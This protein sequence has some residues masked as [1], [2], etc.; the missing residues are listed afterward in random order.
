MYHGAITI[1]EKQYTDRWR[2]SLGW[3]TPSV[4]IAR[5]T[6]H[7]Y[8]CD[9]CGREHR[10]TGPALVAFYCGNPACP[11]EVSIEVPSNERKPHALYPDPV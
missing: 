5:V 10:F 2:P 6:Q 3:T 4:R 1:A 7:V 11:A 8:V 9:R